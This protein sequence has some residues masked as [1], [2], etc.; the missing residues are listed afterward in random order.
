MSI[1]QRNEE[2]MNYSMDINELLNVMIVIID[3]ILGYTSNLSIQQ[4][5]IFDSCPKNFSKDTPGDNTDNNSTDENSSNAEDCS[6]EILIIKYYKEFEFSP[7]LLI[8]SL[9][10]LDKLLDSKFIL[11]SNNVQKVLFICMMITQKYYDDVNYKNKDYA[12]FFGITTEELLRLELEFLN[13]IDFKI[14]IHPEEYNKYIIKLKRI[15]NS[16]F[17]SNITT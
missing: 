7:N 6:I 10:N 2:Q 5:S 13:Y 14:F 1:V 3:K 16:F 8:L 9:M 4:A 12:D 11:S 15:Y 17:Q